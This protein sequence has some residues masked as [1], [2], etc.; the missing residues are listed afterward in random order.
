MYHVFL[1]RM[2]ALEQELKRADAI[3]GLPVRDLA[4][5]PA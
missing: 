4:E 3:L 2:L 5:L 1:A